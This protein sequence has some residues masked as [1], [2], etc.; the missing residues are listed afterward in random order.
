MYLKWFVMTIFLVMGISCLFA[1][2]NPGYFGLSPRDRQTIGL[3]LPD[4]QVNTYN[5]NLVVR[6]PLFLIP[7][8]GLPAECYLIHN[9]DH[10]LVSSA[11]GQGWGF[12]YHARYLRHGN[13]DVTIVWGSGRQDRFTAIPRAAGG[14]TPPNGLYMTLSEPVLGQLV[15]TDKRG[16][17]FLF[18]DAIHQKLTA[19]SDPNGNQVSLGYNLSGT[20]HQVTDSSGR[21]MRLLYD[22]GLLLRRLRDVTM[23]R[24][25]A[26]T[27]DG[28]DR[29]TGI[30]DP[31]GQMT[32]YQY[33]GEHLLT[34]ITDKRG[35]CASISYTTPA[36]HSGT[37]LP[38]MIVKNVSTTSFAYDQGNRHTTV[39]DGRGNDWRYQYDASGHAVGLRD[40]DLKSI[41]LGWDAS[42]NLSSAADRN[43]HTH[44]YTYDSLG[45]RLSHTDPLGQIRTWS[46]DPVYSR[47]TA[48]TDRNT[49]S[50][51]FQYDGM[52]NLIAITDPL[53]NQ[54]S[55][56]Y[57]GFGQPSTSTD[58]ASETTSYTYDGHGNMISVTDPLGGVRTH[59]YDS[60]SREIQVSDAN[61]N[62]TSR[63]FDS[64]NRLTASTNPWGGQTTLTY[65]GEENLAT[66][67]DPPGATISFT[68]DALGRRTSVQDALG[69]TESYSYDEMGNRTGITDRRG[70]TTLFDYDS[71]GRLTQRTTPLGHTWGYGYDCE[72]N[73]TSRIDPMGRTIITTFDELDRITS[74]T[75]PGPI[76]TTYTYDGNRNLTSATQPGSSLTFSYDAIN[77]MASH[78]DVDLGKTLTLTYDVNGNLLDAIRP[79]GDTQVFEY[80]I[81]DRL[82]RITADGRQ[83]DYDHDPGGLRTRVVRPGPIITDY[84]YDSLNR[85]A[86]QE[87]SDGLDILSHT[88]VYSADQLT[89]TREDGTSH[90]MTFDAL[91]RMTRD[92]RTGTPAYDFNYS[93]DPNGNITGNSGTTPFFP[94]DPL[95]FTYNAD[96]Q[97]MTE[98]GTDFGGPYSRTYTYDDNGNLT[99]KLGVGI[100]T[101]TYVYDMLNRLVSA[102]DSVV[103]TENYSYDA[104]GR[105][106]AIEVPVPAPGELGLQRFFYDQDHNIIINYDMAG[107]IQEQYWHNHG[108]GSVLVDTTVGIDPTISISTQAF[109]DSGLNDFSSFGADDFTVPGASWEI[110]ILGVPGK[111]GDTSPVERELF[112]EPVSITIPNIFDLLLKGG[113]KEKPF[114]FPKPPKGGRLFGYPGFLAGKILSVP[115]REP[116]YGFSRLPDDYLLRKVGLSSFFLLQDPYGNISAGVAAGLA[117]LVI[118]VYDL[119]KRIIV[120]GD[121]GPI[122]PGGNVFYRPRINSF[123]S[124]SGLACENYTT[125]RY[126]QPLQRDAFDSGPVS[127]NEFE[128]KFRASPPI[129]V[130]A[131]YFD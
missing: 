72:N 97:V 42:D 105:L 11:F 64:L 58:P 12:S 68:Y 23:N 8:R 41:V 7:A 62:T 74:K 59:V 106:R 87:T 112:I 80:N 24:E 101:V 128:T 27:Y 91:H 103:G 56:S 55:I 81:F 9:T 92:V 35:H 117:G 31:L 46:Y 2:T 122:G 125:F 119:L 63:V 18:G 104:L 52:G 94:N 51:G 130:P 57:D 126:N 33:D 118:Q 39:T 96:N 100:S 71:I 124:R 67:T 102:T 4:I 95:A 15:L 29:L 69:N 114:R 121:P 3:E 99:Q 70:N 98:T 26:F 25:Y 44:T 22:G 14:F 120:S 17:S 115:P 78:T 111:G 38:V 1:D 45:N 60:I 108:R 109:L 20:L 34:G 10:R 19:I 40:P 86:V 79:D 37:R 21:I 30:T 127:G 83:F 113:I 110:E 88:L 75:L 49:N 28:L 54:T 84:G 73:P 53:T 65:D 16:I 5:G 50:W 6:V 32:Q 47:I 76:V 85:L 36:H 48:Y 129:F 66:I 77:R 13:G 116:R 61:G 43:G 107:T 93:H 123:L 82:S 89:A 131:Y 90:A